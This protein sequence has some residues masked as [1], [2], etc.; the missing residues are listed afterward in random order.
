MYLDQQNVPGD[1]S[2][3]SPECFGSYG[4]KDALFLCLKPQNWFRSSGNIQKTIIR[5]HI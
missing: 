3:M 5:F 4:V 1:F 2:F